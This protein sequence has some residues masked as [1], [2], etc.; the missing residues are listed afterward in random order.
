MKIEEIDK[1]F[2]RYG[3]SNT[4]IACVASILRYYHIDTTNIDFKEIIELDEKGSTTLEDIANTIEIFGLV[5]EGFQADSIANLDEV[6]KPAIIPVYTDEGKNDFAVYY[7]KY[8]TKHLIGVPFWGLNL[9]T[10]WEFEAI[11][12]NNILLEVRKS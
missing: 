9:Y 6:S 12:N 1:T 5:T 7:G 3:Y 11:W 4:A 2:F 8:E 10:E